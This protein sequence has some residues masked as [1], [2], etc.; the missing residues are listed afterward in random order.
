MTKRSVHPPL[1]IVE[2][3]R[4]HLWRIWPDGATQIVDDVDYSKVLA[5]RPHPVL[6]LEHL[7]NRE[8]Y[9]F[10]TYELCETCR[11]AREVRQL[12]LCRETGEDYDGSQSRTEIVEWL[13]GRDGEV[14]DA[15]NLVQPSDRR[16]WIEAQTRECP[17]E[18]CHEGLVLTGT[19]VYVERHEILGRVAA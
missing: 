11:G 4:A 17:N 19:G 18:S 12:A 16:I 9:E 1:V 14:V 5:L 3:G 7:Q 10:M 6:R 8:K 15:E 2:D 13:E